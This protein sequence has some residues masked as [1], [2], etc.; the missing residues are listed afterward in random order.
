MKK[1]LI[2][3]T[4]LHFILGLKFQFILY[5]DFPAHFKFLTCSHKTNNLS[6]TDT[7][8]MTQLIPGT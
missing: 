8:L 5:T 6:S 4:A 2:F 3:Y 1:N 7:A